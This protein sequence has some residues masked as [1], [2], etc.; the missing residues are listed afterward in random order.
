MRP[1]T[2]MRSRAKGCRWPSS[3]LRSSARFCPRPSGGGRPGRLSSRTSEPPL[4]NSDTTLSCAGRFWPSPEDLAFA[5]RYSLC[6]ATRRDS[7]IAS[8]PGRLP[9]PEKVESDRSSLEREI[10]QDES[11]DH[12]DKSGHSHH[13]GMSHG[14]RLVGFDPRHRSDDGED[15][16]ECEQHEPIHDFSSANGVPG[17][18]APKPRRHRC[19]PALRS[20]RIRSRGLFSAGEPEE[21]VCPSRRSSRA[22]MR[23]R[24]ARSLRSVT[25][26]S[27]SSS[28]TS[29]NPT[30]HEPCRSE[31]PHGTSEN[32]SSMHFPPSNG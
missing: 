15:D 11:D 4:A 24:A 5:A 31:E 9:D 17:F 7:S 13:A 19:A 16:R 27:N 21:V 28:R 6:Y 32:R 26:R 29:T 2:S 20:S 10:G 8:W 25:Q 22:R 14:P 18:T 23:S 12:Q 3:V 1:D 30:E